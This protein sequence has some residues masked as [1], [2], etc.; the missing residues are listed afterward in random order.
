MLF[1]KLDPLTL[2]N[3][4]NKVAVKNL[5]IFTVYIVFR[6]DNIISISVNLFIQFLMEHKNN[7]ELFHINETVLYCYVVVFFSTGVG[8]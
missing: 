6:F 5:R 7:C 8:H 2:D 1:L 3:K 4:V